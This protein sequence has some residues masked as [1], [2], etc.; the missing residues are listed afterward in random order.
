MILVTG[1]TGFIGRALIRHLVANGYAVRTL[2]RPS[3]NSPRLPVG[4][5]VEVAVVSLGD[6]RGIR[7]A[8]RDIDMVFHLVSAEGQ[9]QNADLLATDIQ[10]TKNLAQAAAD[11]EI[12]RLFYVSHL[13]ADR[14]S[15]FPVLKAK[16][17]AEEHIRCSGVPYTIFRTSIV[18]GPED[19]F[20]TVLARLMKLSPLIFPIPGN[21]ETLIQPLWIEDLVTCMLW[22]I[23]QPEMV[24]Q[25]Y[26]MG[27]SEYFRLGQ[28]V[29]I[30]LAN[31]NIRR[32]PVSLSTPTLRA[33]I[34]LMS[35][36]VKEFPISSFWL[37]YFAVNRTC[38][39]DN[40]PR[41][42]G[43]MPARFTYRL[44]YLRKPAWYAVI[45][46]LI[47]GWGVTFFQGIRKALQSLR[48]S[49]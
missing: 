13:G 11:A 27:G 36:W 35:S 28:V 37:D 38:P 43:L 49:R 26:E 17:I 18:Y 20:T 30:L 47:T 6:V 39:M 15:G 40:L 23:D 14:A 48:S 10:G 1:G 41:Y 29:H 21:H 22:S 4:V 25:T 34:V 19:H 46:Q 7:A 16:G 45:W 44:E 3:L 9:G 33:L 42:F 2:I 8:L 5:P 12:K 24:N 31:M 32:F